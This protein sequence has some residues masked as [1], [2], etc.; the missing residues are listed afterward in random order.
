MTKNIAK[1]IAHELL[2]IGAVE[3]NPKDPYTWASGLKA[4]IYTDNRLIISHPSTRTKVAKAIVK[5]IQNE[6]KEV[7]VIAGTATAGIPHA[8]I[9]AHLMDLPMVY[10]RSSAKDHGKQNAIEGDL[11]PGAKVVMVED[12]ISTGASVIQAASS[13]EEAGGH[14]IGSMAIFSYLLE[15]SELNFEKVSYPLVTLTDYQTLVDI[16]T[17]DPQ[18]N[19]YKDTLEQWY[20]DPVAWSQQFN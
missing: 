17:E 8:S 13:V 18:L 7:E 9:I 12:L 20:K 10:V 11:K 2:N 3:F 19:E 15:Q 1:E 6:F 16:A 4:P 14:V 5:M